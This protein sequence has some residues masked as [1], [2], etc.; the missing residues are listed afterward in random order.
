MTGTEI[1]ALRQKL[2]ITQQELA[3]KIGTAKA[4]ISTWEN[5]HYTPSKSF[6]IL[7]TQL[8]EPVNL[9]AIQDKPDT[10]THPKNNIKPCSAQNQNSQ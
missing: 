10:A 7:M 2:G 9:Q 8:A 3:E 5:G 6:V 4:R 1:K